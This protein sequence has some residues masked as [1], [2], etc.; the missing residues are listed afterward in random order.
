M[1]YAALTSTSIPQVI[2]S[3]L[4][5]AIQL[6]QVNAHRQA[7]ATAP[8]P[9][10]QQGTPTV[11]NP[12]QPFLHQMMSSSQVQPAKRK[13]LYNNGTICYKQNEHKTHYKCSQQETKG[14]SPGALV[15]GGANGGFGGDDVLVIEW[16][17]RK[18]VVTGLDEH[19]LVDLPMATCLGLIITNQG[20]AIAVMHQYAQHG[21]G[22]TIHSTVQLGHFGH[23]VNSTS[24]K[25]PCGTGKQRIITPDGYIIPLDIVDG[26]PYMPMSKPTQEDRDKFPHIILT[27][28]TEWDPRCMDHTST[29][30]NGELNDPYDTL[31]DEGKHYEHFEQW[32]TSIGEII[33]PDDEY[34]HHLQDP[35]DRVCYHLAHNHKSRPTEP[36]FEALCLNFGWAPIGI[37][38]KIFVGTYFSNTPT[39]GGAVK[40]AT[41]FVESK[42]LVN[43]VY[44]MIVANQATSP[45]DPNI[46]DRGAMGTT[47]Y[48]GA[49]AVICPRI[50]NLCGTY[51]VKNNLREPHHQHPNYAENKVETLKDRTNHVMKRSRA[52]PNLWLLA[53]MY[54]CILLYRMTINS[55][56]NITPFNVLLGLTPD[57]SM[58]LAFSSTEPM[59]FNPDNKSPSESI[60]LSGRFAG[61]EM[62]AGDAMTFKV[63][64]DDT[65]KIITQSAVRSRNTL[66][67]PNLHLSPAGGEMND[68][69]MSEPVQNCIHKQDTKGQ[70]VDKLPTDDE[71]PD[72]PLGPDEFIGRSFLLEHDN[73]GQSLR[74]NIIGKIGTFDEETQQKIET[75]LLRAVP[76]HMMDQLRDY[77]DLLEKLDEQS[78]KEDNANF[79]R[80]VSATAHQGPLMPKDPEYMGSAWNTLI[81]WED[82]SATYEPL[83]DKAKDHPD[84]C[85]QHA[86]DNN[87]LDKHGWK[88]FK[89]HPKNKS[90][91][92]RKVNQRKEQHKHFA[93][94]FKYGVKIPQDWE[95]ARHLNKHNDNTKWADSDQLEIKQLFDYEF[96]KDRG[97]LEACDPTLEGYMETRC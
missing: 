23:D 6:Q 78:F 8:H 38:K 7:P 24:I 61:S 11:Q 69:L 52:P 31:T 32:I 25:S 46:K 68:H 73:N 42:P 71:A 50:K 41:I 13:V 63:L 55:L 26:L 40:M 39:I 17:N 48:D 33:H 16:E 44:P 54:V 89:L 34:D 60:E 85:A 10:K 96:A 3:A 51:T 95:S 14:K 90:T 57:A 83:T 30:A 28:D 9:P 87:L 36:D 2:G 70:R 94:V 80:L 15:D 64:I 29:D 19:K 12:A 88:Q 37:T 21:K 92:H 67:D 62:D 91:L 82:G 84:L 1:D 5:A 43:K 86:L 35:H 45:L 56:G 76:D 66:K 93:P 53:L 72:G 59:L 18:A 4:S 27:G 65:K 22:K 49:K 81:N 79:F 20:P 97:K 75:H 74:A 77:H 47:I 58:P